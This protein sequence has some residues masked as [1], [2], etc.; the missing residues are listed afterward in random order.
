MVKAMPDYDE[1]IALRNLMFAGVTYCYQSKTHNI[2]D[3][4]SMDD[5]CVQRSPDFQITGTFYNK[6]DD[7]FGI[8]GMSHGDKIIVGAVKGTDESHI[9][10]WIVDFS[11]VYLFRDNCSLGSAT[12]HAHEGFCSEYHALKDAGMFDAIVA[13]TEAY[14]TYQVVVTG[15][16]LGAAVVMLL[17]MDLMLSNHIPVS[18]YTYGQP[19]T[20]A[21]GYASEMYSLIDTM[22]P[23]ELYRITHYKDMIAHIPACKTNSSGLC[24]QDEVNA[25][26]TGYQIHYNEDFS[27]LQHCSTADGSDCNEHYPDSIQDHLYYFGVRVSEVCC[28]PSREIVV[29]DHVLQLALEN[30][31]MY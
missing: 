31:L 7:G 22:P 27:K 29:P 21:G 1:N 23:S 19:R 10:D 3:W 16:S 5:T 11:N 9:A 17:A 14:P 12:D 8:V 24:I 25:Y 20:V 4:S 26:H 13:L 6:T 30:V 18:I 28:P 2:S 15:H